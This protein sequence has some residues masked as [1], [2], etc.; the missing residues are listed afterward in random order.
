MWRLSLL[1]NCRGERGHMPESF[2]SE[3]PI[4]GRACE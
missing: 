1:A 2:D 4:A 3:T